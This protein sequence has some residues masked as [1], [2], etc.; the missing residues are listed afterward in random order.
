MLGIVDSGSREGAGESFLGLL[1]VRYRVP[2]CFWGR[3]EKWQGSS[4]ILCHRA[5]R[6]TARGLISY[7]TATGL[8]AAKK[9]GWQKLREK[10]ENKFSKRRWTKK[11]NYKDV[12]MDIWGLLLVSTR[13]KLIFPLQRCAVLSLHNSCAIAKECQ[14]SKGKSVYISTYTKKQI[15]AL[16]ER[17]FHL[18]SSLGPSGSG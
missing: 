18:P 10:I 17:C 16:Y 15:K 2:V 13:M 6:L 4:F 8:D 3:Q 7:S 14:Q 9:R 5:G 1:A 12:V 11:A